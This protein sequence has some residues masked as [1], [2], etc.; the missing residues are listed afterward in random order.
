MSLL[1]IF[2]SVGTNFY[3]LT[4]RLAGLIAY[5]FMF[6]FVKRSGYRTVLFTVTLLLIKCMLR[7]TL[8]IETPKLQ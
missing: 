1:S 8:A 2:I 6:Y 5:S 4:V 7:E 3:N